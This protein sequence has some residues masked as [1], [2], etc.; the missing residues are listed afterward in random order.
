MEDT[1]TEEDKTYLRI[2]WGKGYRPSEWIQ[3]EQLYEDMMASYDIQG[4]GHIDTLK[5]VCK[6]S[7]KANQLI[8]MGDVE[9]FQKMSK[10]YDQLMKS[11][12]FTAAQNKGESGE[13]IDSLGELVALC[14]KQEFIPRYYT[15]GPQDKVDRVLE[16]LQHYTKT[17]VT[18]EMNLGNLIEQSIKQ[19]AEQMAK[20]DIVS[21]DDIDD[22]NDD[23]AFERSL[24]D[25]DEPIIQTEDYEELF[26]QE[27]ELALDDV[28]YIESLLNE[29]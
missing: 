18:E 15:D 11:G 16:D 27:E 4:A 19:I 22:E 29:D 28:E 1:L 7:L 25:F 8:D 26:D 5:L 9:G 23:D 21:E 14:E 3:L 17:L 2:K 12:K 6:T 20:E 13:F 10:V 24:F